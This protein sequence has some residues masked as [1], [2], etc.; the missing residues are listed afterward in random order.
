MNIPM[1]PVLLLVASAVVLSLAACQGNKP[2]QLT[3][4]DEGR[5]KALEEKVQKIQDD[6]AK[7]SAPNE[8]VDIELHGVE[9]DVKIAIVDPPRKEACEHP[10]SNC[11]Q[12]VRWKVSGNL[13]EGWRVDIKEKVGGT[14]TKC[15]DDMTF[16]DDKPQSQ[17]PKA[18]CQKDGARWWYDVLLIGKDGKVKDQK[19]P[20]V[21]MNWSP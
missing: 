5:I 19:D 11:G 2:R 15:F 10:Q 1:R 17:E 21:V 7:A 8:K 9:P 13:P 12:H 14:P 18:D 3:D 20:L 4:L 16:T 6:L